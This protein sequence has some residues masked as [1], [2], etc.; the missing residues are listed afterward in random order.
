MSDPTTVVQ[1]TAPSLE[2]SQL[3]TAPAAVAAAG[4]PACF[5]GVDLHKCTVSLDARKPDQ[6]LISR[7]KLSTKCVDRL[8][9]WLS[10]LPQP[11]HLAVEACPFVEWF[12]DFVRPIVEDQGGRIDIAD[13]TE[14]EL[15]RG[16][17]R[18]TDGNDAE[19]VALAL[20]RGDCPLGWIADEQVMHLRKLGRHWRHLSRTISRAKHGMASIF[21]AANLAGPKNDA[22][23]GQR[24]L[25]AHDQ[26]L[27]PASRDALA[28]YIDLIALIERQRVKL[29]RQIIFA[30]RE[31]RFR[32]TVELLK[33]VPGIDEIWA[34]IIAA[35]VGDFSRFP[36]ADALE[37]WA[38]IVPKLEESAGRRSTGNITKAGSKTLRWALGKAAVTLCQ[39]DAKWEA[40]RQRIIRRRGK[41]AIANVAMGRRLLR[42]L[43]AMIRDN[44]PFQGGQPRPR[45]QAANAARARRRG[46]AGKEAA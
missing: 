19:Q 38:G 9:Q 18:K 14:L 25:L 24:W 32:G 41:K 15:R 40:V 28:N 13:A 46:G 4:L 5:V 11:I 43:F 2:S 20:C 3:I 22:D 35:E 31:E 26:L 29:R 16:K 1:P 37:F 30:N 27:K 23:S 36:S 7:T 6:N 39:C 21:H 8:A 44:K 42:T 17:R 33:S 10:A 34:C 45:T 12:I